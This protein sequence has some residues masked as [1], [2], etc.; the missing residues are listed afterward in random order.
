MAEKTL[1][2]YPI[3]LAYGAT[4]L[5]YSKWTPHHGEDRGAPK[6]T[7]VKVGK[8]VIGTVGNTGFAFGDHTHVDKHR[9][10]ENG[11]KKQLDPKGWS[12]IKGTVD[13]KGWAGTAG[14]MVIIKTDAGTYFRFLHLDKIVC[15]V[16][17]K[18]Y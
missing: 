4:S 3:T 12:T 5:P 7:K 13:W 15:S 14:K 6:G 1:K 9:F 2:D 10:D 16:G 18:T 17:D 8:L 11:K